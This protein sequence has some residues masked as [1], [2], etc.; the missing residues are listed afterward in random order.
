LWNGNPLGSQQAQRVSRLMRESW[1]SKL[2]VLYRC[3]K[4]HPTLPR[5]SR[6]RTG[7]TCEVDTQPAITAISRAL[8]SAAAVTLSQ[9]L[10]AASCL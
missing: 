10:R 5:P 4:P 1:R 9:R 8:A 7:Q 2:L 6:Q 3:G